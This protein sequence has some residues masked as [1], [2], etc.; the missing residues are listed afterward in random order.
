[1]TEEWA[2]DVFAEQIEGLKAGGADVIWIE[3]MSSFEEARAAA[4][5]ARRHGMPY[6]TTG[7]FD[8]AGR[9][10]MGIAPANWAQELTHLEQPPLAV[11]A[12]CGVGASDL[13]MTIL[14]M[15]DAEPEAVIVAKGNCGVPKDAGRQDRLHRHAGVM[16][17]Y[18]RFAVDAGA[19]IIGGCC[20]TSC[21][22]LAAMRK[23]IDGHVK[24]SRPTAEAVVEALGPSPLPRPPPAQARR[25]AAAGGD[26]ALKPR[27][28]PLPADCRSWRAS[29]AT[30][31]WRAR[32]EALLAWRAAEI[33]VIAFGEMRGR[34]EA[35]GQADRQDRHRGLHQHSVFAR[36]RRSR[37]SSASAFRQDSA[38]TNAPAGAATTRPRRQARR[39]RAAP[40]T[41][42]P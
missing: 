16:A 19:R 42:F 13:L 31:P 15:T 25:A 32:A 17:E 4:A 2:T 37:D 22:H 20:G 36:S 33:L 3:T 34:D 10:M 12:N 27:R 1:M 18:A 29:C 5:A 30:G 41:T 35:A 21:H 40:P 11:G 8:T 6:V 24:R 14:A 38:G 23:A 9:T 39:R 28:A 7:S 26:R